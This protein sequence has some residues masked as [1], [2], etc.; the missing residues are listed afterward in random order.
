MKGK[1]KR[2]GQRTKKR[3]KYNEVYT[4]HPLNPSEARFP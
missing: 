3:E 4:F 2:D 1:I